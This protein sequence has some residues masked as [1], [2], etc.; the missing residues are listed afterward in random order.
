MKG[1]LEHILEGG[2]FI[3][4]LGAIGAILVVYIS[5][6]IIGKMF[7]SKKNK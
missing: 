3:G 1:S 6:I 4:V 5:M 7:D 2:E